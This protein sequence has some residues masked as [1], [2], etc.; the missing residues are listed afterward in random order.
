MKTIHVV[1]A[2][3]VNDGTYFATQRGY[4]EFQGGWEFPGGKIEAG[5][6]PQQA[7]CREIKEELNTTIAVG[8]LLTVVEYDYPQF[9]LSMQCFMCRVIGGTLQL[10]EAEAARWLKLDELDQVAWLPADQQVVQMLK[11]EANINGG[12]NLF[13]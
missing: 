12:S 13:L 5:E 3:I 7:L 10:L 2:I 11:S 6:T 9:H 4:G 1:A 8:R